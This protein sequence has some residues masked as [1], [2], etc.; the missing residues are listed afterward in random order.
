MHAL[1]ND[2]KCVASSAGPFYLYGSNVV[3]FCAKYGT[4]YV[5]ITGE[6]DWVKTMIMKWDEKAQETGAKL[7]SCCGCD[8]IPWD[9][10]VYK[11]A[12]LL[13]SNDDELVEVNC[14]NDMKGGGPSGGTLATMLINLDGKTSHPK[15]DINPLLKLPDGSKSAAKT[16]LLPVLIPGSVSEEDVGSSLSMKGESPFVMSAVNCEIIKRTQALTNKSSASSTSL[17]FR[18]VLLF[19]D[20]KTAFMNWFTLV[21]GG[22]LIF[23]PFRNSVILKPGEG[24]TRKMMDD[25]Y[26][27]VFGYGKGTKGNIVESLLY[28]PN[29]VGYK[30]TAR[31]LVESG[32]TLALDGEKMP[33]KNGGCYS[34]AF[35]MGDALLDRLSVGGTKFFSRVLPENMQ[36]KL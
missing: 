25:G 35:C 22:T 27:A 24:P 13:K 19:K 4:H 26:L 8:S 36:S 14:Y 2:A 28:Y 23:T 9:L 34:P 18:D 32:L 16:K 12:Q 5:D 20:F 7:V 6:V 17:K 11:M 33:V 1:V 30:D 21:A 29:E 10:S 31:M 15:Y 3:E